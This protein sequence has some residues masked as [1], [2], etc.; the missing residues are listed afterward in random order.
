VVLAVCRRGR[1]REGEVVGKYSIIRSF[2]TYNF[3]EYFHVKK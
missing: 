2:I 3:F 1:G